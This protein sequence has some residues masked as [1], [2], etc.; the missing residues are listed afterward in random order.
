MKGIHK[1]LK[2]RVML[3]YRE[4][5]IEKAHELG[6][7]RSRT[8]SLVNSEG[9]VKTAITELK[10]DDQFQNCLL[11]VK[12]FYHP[13]TR[14]WL[15]KTIDGWFAERNYE[16][17]ADPE[18]EDNQQEEEA[19]EEDEDNSKTT[20]NGGIKQKRRRKHKC[21]RGGWSAV[22]RSGK[23]DECGKYMNALF[24]QQHW[25]IIHTK[26]R[27][28]EGCKYRKLSDL[29][30]ITDESMNE[31]WLVTR[32]VRIAYMCCT[33]IYLPLLTTFLR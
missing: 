31:Y 29:I 19:E 28:V 12:I 16:L 18:T 14:T 32:E 8:L 23:G 11:V 6:L 2:D 25:K 27:E 7:K 5:V 10:L 20:D 26:N 30:Q 3:K 1:D 22:A 13:F 17:L 21:K 24:R 4:K 33:I 9:D 15:S